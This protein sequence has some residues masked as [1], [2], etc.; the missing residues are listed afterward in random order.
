MRTLCTEN[1][2]NQALISAIA[3]PCP[4]CQSPCEKAGGCNQMRC[5]SCGAHFC[6]LCGQRVDQGTFPSHFQWWNM[7][8]CPNMQ[9]Q[10]S[11]EAPPASHMRLMRILSAVQVVV[12]GPAALAL[13][14]AFYVAFLPCFLLQWCQTRRT[15]E[16]QTQFTGCVSF[17]GNALLALC[18]APFLLLLL[19]LVFLVTFLHVRPSGCLLACVLSKDTSDETNHIQTHTNHTH[20]TG[21]PLLGLLPIRL[22]L[23]RRARHGPHAFRRGISRSRNSGSGA[24]AG[25]AVPIRELRAVL[26]GACVLI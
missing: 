24:A 22:L 26:H 9:M 13:G 16:L 10:E 19:L 6:W 3:K 2:K 12:L 11:T 7:K 15:E 25:V 4:Q 1:L 8:G 23:P 18:V 17:W 5:V 14:L 21:A 20:N